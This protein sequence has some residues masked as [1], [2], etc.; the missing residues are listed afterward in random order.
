MRN[1]SVKTYA[2]FTGGLNL[3]SDGFSLAP[4]EASDLLNVDIDARGGFKMREG[5]DALN[6]TALAS[7]P[8]SLWMF[9]GAPGAAVSQ[10]MVSY[11]TKLAYSTGGNFTD[12]AAI[13]QTT[14]LAH[15]AAVA[16]GKCYIQNGTDGAV[17][18]TGSAGSR[19]NQTFNDN[20]AAPDGGDMPVGRCIAYHAGRMW[21]A[22]TLESSVRYPNL[23]RFS[24]AANVA[25]DK[26]PEDWRTNDSFDVDIGTDGDEIVALVPFGERLLIFK[27]R[28]IY[29]VAGYDHE[30][31]QVITLIKGVGA[32]GPNAVVSTE[33]GVYFFDWPSGVHVIRGGLPEYL[34]GMLR[35]AIDEGNIPD[36]YSS[37]ITMGYSAR[38]LYVGVPWGSSTKNARTFVLDTTVAKGASWVVY[39]L[40]LG[41]MAEYRSTNADVILHAI[42]HG[43][44]AGRGLRVLRLNRG[45]ASDDF[46]AGATH[47][48]SHYLTRWY[49]LGDPAVR[50]KFRRPM[51]VLANTA[52]G[53]IGVDVYKDFNP[54]NRTSQFSLTSTAMGAGGVWDTDLWDVGVWTG[55]DDDRDAMEDGSTLGLG[56]AVAFKFNGPP[57]NVSWAIRSLSIKY[58]P[59]RVH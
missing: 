57:T 34:F 15:V 1:V 58:V 50:K 25:N 44:T 22:N 48:T 9:E 32:C 8:I 27:R 11:G 20:L 35:P 30:T 23:V 16:Q 10:R 31:F 54:S 26:G 21:V 56:H 17:V 14:G 40:A 43:A 19:L 42:D 47:I 5:V 6:S 12:V 13:A 29:M 3:R 2:D 33:Q 7:A 52:T 59:R 28:A 36:A 45:T 51:F 37:G 38:R 49:D 39:D 46:G 18:W 24:H 55:S 53:V 41:P 4:N